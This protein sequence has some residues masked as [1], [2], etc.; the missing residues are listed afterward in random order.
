[1]AGGCNPT[2]TSW[3]APQSFHGLTLARPRAASVTIAPIV[4]LLGK[5]ARKGEVSID[6]TTAEK[7][8]LFGSVKRRG[9]AKA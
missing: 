7:L 8:H 2:G 6:A 9:P 3:R 5:T 4:R 1:M